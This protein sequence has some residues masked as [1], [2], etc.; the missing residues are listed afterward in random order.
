MK[1]RRAIVDTQI[2][3]RSP[4]G[5]RGLKFA[6]NHPISHIC[7]RSPHGERGLKWHVRRASNFRTSRS[8]HGE[9]GLKY[10]AATTPAI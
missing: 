4:H 1:F 9:R 5:E 7:S 3:G 6:V 10:G 8:P 2:V